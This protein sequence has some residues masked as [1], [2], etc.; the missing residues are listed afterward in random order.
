MSGRRLPR[1]TTAVIAAALLAAPAAQALDLGA[2][3]QA[4]DT[5]QRAS[6]A[7]T[8]GQ[9]A[10]EA[11][12]SAASTATNAA[13]GAA[14][15]ARA[16]WD[17]NQAQPEAAQSP[18]SGTAPVQDDQGGPRRVMAVLG[19]AWTDSARRGQAVVA[20]MDQ[21]PYLV[22]RQAA[23]VAPAKSQWLALPRGDSTGVAIELPG[24]PEGTTYD[25]ST[26]RARPGGRGVRIFA[27]SVHADVPQRAGRRSL[28]AIEQ[29]AML[30]ASSVRTE[31][32]RQSG[33]ILEPTG[34]KLLVWASDATQR[35]PS[36]FGADGRLFTADDPMV[37]LPRGYTVVTLEPQGLRFD[38]AREIALAFHAVQP[39]Q[40]IDLSRLG[41]GD[42]AQ[43]LIGLIAERHP[44]AAASGFDAGKL[45]ADYGQRLQTAAERGD[46]AAQA[47]ALAEMGQRLGDGQYRVLLPGGQ[48]WPARTDRG[49]SPQLLARGSVNMPMPRTWLRED[50][51]IAITSVAPGSAAAKAGLQPGS[52]IL[53]IE[54][55][56]PARY[57]DRIAPASLRAG[58]DA[59]RADLL[60][61][62]LGTPA[63]LS[64]RTA[65]GAS[66]G[67]SGNQEQ[68]LRLDAAPAATT[69]L[70]A[71]EPALASFLLRSAQGGNLAYIALDSFA[72]GATGQLNR[73]EGAL[74][75]ATQARVTG[76]VID[77]R[78]HRGDDAYQLVPHMLA[79]LY[80]RDK[81][82]R[83]QDAA[84]RLF[85]PAARVWRSR[86]GLGLPA[87][88]PLAATG[89]PFTAP[90]AVLTGPGCAGPCELF[91]AWLQHSQRADIVATS[92]PAG[93]TGPATRVHLPAGF[94]VQVP[95]LAETGP[96][97]GNNP[98]A[99]AQGVTPR[100]RVPVD[101][102]FT[103][104]VQAGGDPLLD[105]AVLHL[106]RARAVQASR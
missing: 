27:L 55:E 14:S 57:L 94:I 31:W 75:A 58:A 50:G 101:A 56:S 15:E 93:A 102:A 41:A 22:H 100:L 98:A 83:M 42:A 5:V 105:A 86:G 45:R 59:R 32:P 9:Q 19:D 4:A 40:D 88:L 53:S 103:A 11:G 65:A 29:H 70:P 95:L 72:D 90:V 85:D 48:A 87:Q 13:T 73:W 39:A 96:A 44:L 62:D 82:L 35:F 8:A 68:T 2:I 12:R 16:W 64:L 76:L 66:S 60:A 10:L 33:D 92:A 24:D 97:G 7:A 36:G 52:D 99:Q 1:A 104:S 63:T 89:A 51:R 46:S 49:L 61:L 43:A 80:T 106:E 67:A 81:P 34:G 77:L 28:D 54:G 20:L 37:T 25:L 74:A 71:A 6:G 79:S 69:A 84:Q 91:A 30:R 3:G 38:R 23:H 78:A 26:G 47:Q 18:P 17:R 21:G